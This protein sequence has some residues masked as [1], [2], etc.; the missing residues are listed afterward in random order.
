MPL[1]CNTRLE[2]QNNV[3]STSSDPALWLNELLLHICGTGTRNCNHIVV[4]F[5]D[6][7]SLCCILSHLMVYIYVVKKSDLLSNMRSLHAF[8]EKQPN[9]C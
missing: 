8:K 3:H 7:T 6:L 4:V 5:L 1:K 2:P 9:L